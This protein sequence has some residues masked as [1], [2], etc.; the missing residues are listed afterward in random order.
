MRSSHDLHAALVILLAA[1]AAASCATGRAAAGDASGGTQD[2]GPTIDASC[3]AMCDQDGDGVPDGSDQCP[4]TPAGAPV[5]GLGCA[6]SQL[7]PVLETTFPPYGLT[8]T[9]TGDLGRAGGLT[10]PYTGIQR[11]D[12]FHVFWI[13]CDDP[14][15][16]CGLSLDGPIDTASEAWQ[17]DMAASESRGRHPGLDQLDR[18][19]PRGRDHPATERP[20]DAD[21]C[22][23]R[24][25]GTPLGRC[26]HPRR[27]PARGE[28][29]RRD[30]RHRTSR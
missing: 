25:C 20:P 17:F 23:R 19:L 5:N 4:D 13:V 1:F 16:P 30:P 22:Q 8:W 6:D 27:A 9:P 18:D 7:T 29:R 14:G 11:G 15:T 10:W 28:P 12:L 2:A 26:R 24:R 21:D 3:G